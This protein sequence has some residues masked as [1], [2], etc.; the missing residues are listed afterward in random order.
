MSARVANKKNGEQRA[1]DRVTDCPEI[2]FAKALTTPKLTM[3]ETTSAAD[4][5]PRPGSSDGVAAL[6]TVIYSNMHGAN[7][8]CLRRANP[9]TPG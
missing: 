5:M 3:N 1:R 8:G 7:D 4:A 9:A 2:G 6:F